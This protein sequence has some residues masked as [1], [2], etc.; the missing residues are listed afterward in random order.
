[1]RDILVKGTHARGLVRGPH[2]KGWW[3]LAVQRAS[4]PFAPINSYPL[5][6]NQI[7]S[8]S[9]FPKSLSGSEDFDSFL[10]SRKELRDGD[11]SIHI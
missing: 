5:T 2:R 7:V 6:C 10:P 8:L 11:L 9:F 3:F 1:M 4:I